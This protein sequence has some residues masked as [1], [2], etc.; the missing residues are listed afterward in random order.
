MIKW[1]E[2]YKDSRDSKIMNRLDFGI[3]RIKHYA[4]MRKRGLIKQSEYNKIRK[5]IEDQL[6]FNFIK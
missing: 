4:I 2:V 3:E 5:E 1:D 6:L